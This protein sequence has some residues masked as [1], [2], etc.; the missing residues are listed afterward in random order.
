MELEIRYSH[1]AKYHS[2][3]SELILDCV[4][5]RSLDYSCSSYRPSTPKNTKQT[6]PETMDMERPQIKSLRNSTP[7]SSYSGAAA[8]QSAPKVESGEV[9]TRW[10]PTSIAEMM[11]TGSP[12]VNSTR[13]GVIGRNI[14]IITPEELEYADRTAGTKDAQKQIVVGPATED[15]I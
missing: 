10:E 4:S 3:N 11:E 2:K 14:G 9:S 8:M 7:L 5:K 6:I 1:F 15:I 13:P 12:P